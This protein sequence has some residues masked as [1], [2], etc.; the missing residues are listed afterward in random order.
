MQEEESFKTEV[1]TDEGNDT[2]LN[3]REGVGESYN[4]CDPLPLEIKAITRTTPCL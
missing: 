1:L 4:T 2:L 3:G